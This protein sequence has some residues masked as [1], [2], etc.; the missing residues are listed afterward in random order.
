MIKK[1]CLILLFIV[2]LTGCTSNTIYKKPKD[3][4]PKDTMVALLSD[5][6]IANSA[7]DVRNLNL[8]KELNYT[9]LIREKYQIDST[10]FKSS[11]LYYTSVIDEYE[12]IFDEAL[13]R[14]E[15]LKVELEAAK[16]I[17]DS[18]KRDSLLRV[19]RRLNNPQAKRN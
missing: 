5:M 13:L 6:L 14:L 1:V 19:K 15:A 11:N 4:I 9:S 7:K 16:K 3:L 12:E 10:R 2:I 18:I 8:E 17:H